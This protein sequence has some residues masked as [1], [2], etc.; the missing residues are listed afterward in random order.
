MLCNLS[1]PVKRYSQQD[2]MNHFQ[3][4]KT[5]SVLLWVLCLGILSVPG[6]GTTKS[7]TATEQLLMSDAVDSTI[8]K[9][10]FRPL[11]GIKTYLDT[12]YV[13]GAG[14]APHTFINSDYV[15]SGIR[16]QMLAAGCLLVET[17]EQADIICEARCGALGVDG[18]NV[19]YG[20]P[21][22]NLLANASSLVAGAPALPTIPEISIAKREMNSAAAKVAVFAYERESR[23]PVWQSGVSQAGS[24]ARDTWI[25]G[26]G[27]IQNGSIYGGTKFAGRKLLRRQSQIDAARA[28]ENVVGIDHRDSYVFVKPD[29]S[30][31]SQVA[32][33]QGDE[34]TKEP[35][36]VANAPINSDKKPI[37]R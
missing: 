9:M 37:V 2:R 3:T 14:K 15:I 34:E 27:P 11:S 28:A 24:S 4:L 13:T 20:M 10:D 7:S 17:R 8:A 1:T 16:Q 30:S 6:C 35:A 31:D 25:F 36:Q 5:S 32:E 26:I 12:T 18:H 21:A 19:I 22:N 23:E 29:Y 33:K